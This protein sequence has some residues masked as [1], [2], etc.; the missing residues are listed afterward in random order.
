MQHLKIEDRS[1][2]N[3]DQLLRDLS[4]SSGKESCGQRITSLARL[5]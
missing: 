1:M 4:F 2:A 5:S 3:G